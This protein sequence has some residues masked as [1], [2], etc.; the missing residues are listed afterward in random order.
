M[1]D[2]TAASAASTAHPAVAGPS[3]GAVLWGHQGVSPTRPIAARSWS[4]I[5]PRRSRMGPRYR[6]LPGCVR[7]AALGTLALLGQLPA[8]GT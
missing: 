2:F 6:W 8:T 5:S 1:L 4:A 7:T 3:I